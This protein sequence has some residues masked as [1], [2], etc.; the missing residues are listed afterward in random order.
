MTRSPLPTRIAAVRITLLS[1]L[2]PCMSLRL[3]YVERQGAVVERVTS[4]KP[5]AK[6]DRKPAQNPSRKPARKAIPDKCCVAAKSSVSRIN[7]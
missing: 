4:P 6:P 2:H 7:P 3:L 5:A 1:T